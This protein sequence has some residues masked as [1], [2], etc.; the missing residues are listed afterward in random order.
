MTKYL[1]QKG[2]IE[3]IIGLSSRGTIGIN[4]GFSQAKRIIRDHKCSPSAQSVKSDE[5][6]WSQL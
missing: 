4:G 2:D 1:I 6:K 3:F 5:K